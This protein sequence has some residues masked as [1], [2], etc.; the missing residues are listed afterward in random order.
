[1]F[2][3]QGFRR[4]TITD[5]NNF[6][7]VVECLSIIT[8]YVMLMIKTTSMHPKSN[9]YYKPFNNQMLV[10]QLLYSDVH[11]LKQ[12]LSKFEAVLVSRNWTKAFTIFFQNVKSDVKF[13]HSV[14]YSSHYGRGLWCFWWLLF[15]LQNQ[16]KGTIIISTLD[17]LHIQYRSKVSYHPRARR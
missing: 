7:W 2:N 16:I 9:K 8:S 10:C 4:L 12:V 11:F 5:W 1:M 3:F 17:Q 6:I 14:A 13:E 15:S